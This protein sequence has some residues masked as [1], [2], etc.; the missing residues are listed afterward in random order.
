[1]IVNNIKQYDEYMNS[2]IDIEN[3]LFKTKMEL[4]NEGSS[5]C[6]E[7]LSDLKDDI[8]TPDRELMNKINECFTTVNNYRRHKN[9]DVGQF[10]SLIDNLI[11]ETMRHIKDLDIDDDCYS[12]YV[13]ESHIIADYYYLIM[14]S[15]I[16]SYISNKKY[17]ISENKR[18][19]LN[20]VLLEGVG[21]FLSKIKTSFGDKH[22]KI[23]ARDS[24]WLKSNKKKILEQNFD[25]IELEVASDNK[26]SFANII[27]RHDTFDKN[28][29]NMDSSYDEFYEN[30][31][32]FEDK[33]GNLK[34][35][36]DNYI[37]NGNSRREI[38]LKKVSGD[39]AKQVVENMI[40]YCE[41]F[42]S[43]RGF[44]E[45]KLTDIINECEEY[46]NVKESMIFEVPYEDLNRYTLEY[47]EE[48]NGVEVSNKKAI[49]DG[50][51]TLRRQINTKYKTKE[52]LL[53]AIKKAES[54][55]KKINTEL[56]NRNN[57]FKFKK[58]TRTIKNIMSAGFNNSF[59][60]RNVYW[61]PKDIK[62][63]EDGVLKSIIVTNT[64]FIDVA[65]ER[66]V[67]LDKESGSKNIH[68][69]EKPNYIYT[70][71]AFEYIQYLYEAKKEEE[72]LDDI[73]PDK[74]AEEDEE[75]QEE[76]PEDKTDENKSE[77]E[78]K[79]TETTAD[80]KSKILRD[81]QTGITVL[82]TVA[83]ERYFDYIDL[84]KGLVE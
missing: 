11:F 78:N 3:K 5:I 60:Y 16:E 12:L 43:G 4:I 7:I 14:E 2:Y 13:Q 56:N 22:E 68:Q 29:K 63:I 65:N 66:I 17:T 31:R 28:F 41:E 57:E 37:R 6:F 52:S 73:D 38:S 84:L 25:E 50:K 54:I 15:E 81:R 27:N 34:N 75:P 51:R 21:E 77:E 35:G 80:D 42:L 8:N 10:N 76:K 62:K 32:R 18:V 55:N 26:V 49:A 24:K 46:D 83:E 30:I 1:M 9:N 72:N 39:E 67:E 70:E 79:N 59:D 33:S 40:S 53:N 36:L 44:I 71:E 58:T 23:L 20:D 69:Y 64:V 47:I 19:E 82:M 61:E 48:S 45:G 74:L